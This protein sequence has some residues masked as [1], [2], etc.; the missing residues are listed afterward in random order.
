MT[1]PPLSSWKI[2]PWTKWI[3]YPLLAIPLAIPVLMVVSVAFSLLTSGL[4]HARWDPVEY[5]AGLKYHV[6]KDFREYFH[7]RMDYPA[8]TLEELVA[9]GVL[10]A[11]SSHFL[12]RYPHEYV[13]FAPQTPDGTI[14]LTIHGRRAEPDRFT[15]RDLTA[16]PTAPDHLPE[17]T[18]VSSVP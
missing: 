8:L 7:D 5:S 4:E 6:E 15:K 9:K 18:P 10:S 2:R 17:P 16:D 3:L 1:L 13:P 14:V 11:S 12:D